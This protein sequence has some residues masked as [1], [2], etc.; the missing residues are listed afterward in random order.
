M[1]ISC[2]TLFFQV[3]YEQG[4][5]THTMRKKEINEIH[6]QPVVLIRGETTGSVMLARPGVF[7]AE[8]FKKGR[9]EGEGVTLAMAPQEADALADGVALVSLT[10]V[11]TEEG[12]AELVIVTLPL[13]EEDRDTLIDEL[14]E[15]PEESVTVPEGL[16]ELLM[17]ALVAALPLLLTLAL[18]LALP[19]TL[20]LALALILTLALTLGTEL[21]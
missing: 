5:M 11:G 1:A 12:D 13:A 3:Q 18:A 6:S 9:K 2:S 17:L 20:A 4:R 21:G 14:R 10:I 8:L 15:L 16:M 19:L 7:E